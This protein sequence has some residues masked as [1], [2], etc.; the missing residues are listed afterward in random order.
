MVLRRTC[1]CQIGVLKS[2]H[3]VLNDQI[4]GHVV[5]ICTNYRRRPICKCAYK[6]LVFFEFKIDAFDVF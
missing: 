3:L 1:A 5:C 6:F 2:A 4:N